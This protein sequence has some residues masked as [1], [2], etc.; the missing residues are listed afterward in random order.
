MIVESGQRTREAYN[1]ATGETLPLLIVLVTDGMDSV[2]GEIE[3]LLTSLVS[4]ARALGIR[5]IV[6]MQTPTRRDT[7]WRANLS[8]VLAGP[9]LDRSQDAPAMGL[10]EDSIVYRP[11]LLPSPQK[12]QGA[13]VLRAGNE[14]TLLQ[15][16]Y[17]SDSHFD[18]LCESLPQR[19]QLVKPPVQADDDALL[20][21]LLA[22]LSAGRT[23]T[24][25]TAGNEAHTAAAS[26]VR[27]ENIVSNVVVTPTEAAQIATL[28]TTNSPSDTAKKLYGYTPSR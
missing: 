20:S 15:A 27:N 5:V 12:R 25:G 6:S 10:R 19:T 18:H 2:Q 24:A 21:S 22:G 28:L 3:T 23:V 7:R 4:K 8:T 1:T 11:S 14:Q 16:P 17:I 26:E 9:L 13:F